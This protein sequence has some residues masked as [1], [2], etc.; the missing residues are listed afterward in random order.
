[1]TS[2]VIFHSSLAAI[3]P[4]LDVGLSCG[5]EAISDPKAKGATDFS[6]APRLVPSPRY[7]AKFELLQLW[8][9]RAAAGG[10]DRFRSSL[11][12]PVVMDPTIFARTKATHTGLVE[13]RSR[14]ADG[15]VTEWRLEHT[16]ADRKVKTALAAR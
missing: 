8:P 15:V 10:F 16:A 1:M 11:P 9:G 7:F 6:V 4:A 3:L 5:A 13:G 14:A 2:C 12:S